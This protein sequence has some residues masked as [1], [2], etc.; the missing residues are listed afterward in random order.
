V[1]DRGPGAAGQLGAA[2]F[3]GS[4]NLFSPEVSDVMGG[5]QSATYGLVE[6]H[7]LRHQAQTARSTS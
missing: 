2:S 4:I 1:V 5:S 7:Q 3:G 6:H